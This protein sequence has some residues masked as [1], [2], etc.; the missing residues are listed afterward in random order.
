MSTTLEAQLWASADILRG[1]MDASEYKN[2][3]LGLVFYK[4][5]SDL[6]LREAYEQE[7]G[8]TDTYPDREAQFEVL[9][10]WYEEDPEDLQKTMRLQLG[11]FIT[12][13]QLFYSFRKKADG[14]NLQLTELNNGFTSLEREGEQFQ[15][16]FADIDLKS[17]KLG[18]NDQQRS[19]TVIEVLRALDEI[20]L[21]SHDGDVI[22]DAYG[23]VQERK[24]GSSIRLKLCH[25]SSQK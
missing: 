3:L 24:Q 19:I 9:N 21:F 20:D 15:G 23:Q 4:Y 12:P 7:N 22:G 11:Y 14:Y 8:K 13:D 16:L 1:K 6:E 25:A 10:D 2:Y 5:L 18:S 17:N